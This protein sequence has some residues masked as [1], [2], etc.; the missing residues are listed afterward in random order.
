[1]LNR[2]GGLLCAVMLCF[3]VSCSGTTGANG[4]GGNVTTG[5]GSG[6]GTSG[7][8][9]GPS[10]GGAG[11]SGNT[12]LP[13]GG[14]TGGSST[15]GLGTGGSSASSGGNALAGGAGG[16]KTSGGGGS[17]GSVTGGADSR[18]GGS[19]GSVVGGSG[20][21]AAGGSGGSATGEFSTGVLVQAYDG[22]RGKS[23]NDGWKFYRGDA[24]GAEQPAF[25]DSAWRS[26]SVPHDWS[27]EL[28]FNKNSPAGNGGGLLDGGIGWY[29]KTFTLDPSYS[30]QQIRIAF[31]GVYCNSQ[32]WINGTSLGTRPYGYSTFQ[33]DVTKYA[34]TDGS[35]NVIAV[36]VNNNQP[37]SRWYSGS[38]IYRN[39]WL[40]VL[41]PIHIAYNGGFITTPSV[42]A[43]SATVAITADVENQSSD[44][45]SVTITTGIF[46]A[47]GAMVTSNTT[48]ASSVAAGATSTLNQSLTI[49]T[50]HLWSTD[51][52]YLYR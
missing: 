14:N 33:Y 45:Q 34:K 51:V 11:S 3:A 1:M 30:G 44:S 39:V 41:S 18:T 35:N 28:P 25:N 48:A 37:N 32:V 8:G 15:G 38:G 22:A 43:T 52:P 24:S 40:T 4:S 5:G 23:F 21:S 36:R 20:G 13:R 9:G 17:D 46:D 6:G 12:S 42:S 16:A 31:D 29:R 49:P 10:A 7:Q 27:I 19:G 2:V 47:S 26:L 50:P